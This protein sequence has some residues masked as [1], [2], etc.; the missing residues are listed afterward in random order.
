MH[1]TK[2]QSVSRLLLSLGRNPRHISRYLR[3]LPC[4]RRFPLDLELP[5]MS[6]GVIDY[7]GGALRPHQAVFEF[8]S[9]GSSLFFARR[10]KRVVSVEHDAT[11][12]RLVTAAANQRGITNLDCQFHPIDP[13]KPETYPSLS[14]FQTLSVGEFDIVVVDGFCDYQNA[15]N[16]TLRQIAFDRAITHVRPGGLIIVDDIWMF[17]ELVAR[18][19]PARVHIFASPGPCRYGVTSTAVFQC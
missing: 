16:G 11:W 12:H 3:H 5:W 1:G 15:S 14:Y 19:A 6:Y 17:P 10:V 18:Y 9:G 7:L 4:W 2:F 13:A 8:G